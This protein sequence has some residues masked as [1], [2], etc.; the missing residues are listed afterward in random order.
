MSKD[1]RYACNTE[2]SQMISTLDLDWEATGSVYSPEFC[3]MFL[4]IFLMF[5]PFVSSL[6]IP[7][8]FFKF[9][10]KF[11]ALNLP[12]LPLLVVTDATFGVSATF[13]IYRYMKDSWALYFLHVITEILMKNA[14]L[15]KIKLSCT[16]CPYIVQRRE[17]TKVATHMEN[18]INS[19]LLYFITLACKGENVYIK[20]LNSCISR[21]LHP[22]SNKS[23]T[24][25][26]SE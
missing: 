13:W 8:S 4:I 25:E 5:W 22:V 6:P 14:P 23:L 12:R 15:T 21:F 19:V 1:N 7:H 20:F 9:P 26:C 24:E 18:V 16:S 2:S 17:T 3:V 11:D 10:S